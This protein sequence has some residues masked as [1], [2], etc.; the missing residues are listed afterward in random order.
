MTIKL[1]VFYVIKP[2]SSTEECGFIQK[3]Y[4]IFMFYSWLSIELIKSFL[5]LFNKLKEYKQINNFIKQSGPF[6]EDSSY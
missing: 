3:C 6:V 1:F 2:H 5:K 4:C